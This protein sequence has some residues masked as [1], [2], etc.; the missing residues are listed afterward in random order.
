MI[1]VRKT[2][3]G[4]WIGNGK[5]RVLV[6]D[7]ILDN[8]DELQITYDK[9]SAGEVVYTHYSPLELG[10]SYDS[11]RIEPQENMVVLED[12]TQV[13]YQFRLSHISAEVLYSHTWVCVTTNGIMADL[14]DGSYTVLHLGE[15]ND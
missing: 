10:K 11:A 5:K 15:K 12:E 6:N 13:A 7:Y 8:C 9:Y 3:G 14:P 4:L 2:S 1:E